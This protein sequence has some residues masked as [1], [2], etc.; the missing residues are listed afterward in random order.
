MRHTLLTLYGPFAIHGYGL[1]IFIGLLIFMILI[2]KNKK[3]AELKLE[4]HLNGILLLATCVG[5]LGGR[6][7]FLFSN[8]TF[9]TS[10]FDIFTFYTGGFSILGC[11]LAILLVIPFYLSYLHIP[12]IPFF[13]L[14]A[15][16]TP[17][18]QSISRIGCFL[19]G[20]C[21]GLPTNLPWGIIYTDQESIAPLY[22][23]L[24]PTQLYSAISL[25]VIFTFL[26]FIVQKYY[27]KPGQLL[28]CYLLSIGVER[29]FIEYWRGD[30]QFQ[31]NLTI[32][33]FIALLMITGSIIG[34]I[35]TQLKK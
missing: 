4:S 19:A 10:F 24:H 35:I 33:Q 2:K 28:A 13:D 12:I 14:I 7:L 22:V 8:P 21:Y 26:Y 11:I 3:F 18:L 16:Y 15:L 29:F 30:A 5:L 17:L 9:Y 20:C 1:M 31:S 6:L 32:N 25:L 27:T 23:C 34:L